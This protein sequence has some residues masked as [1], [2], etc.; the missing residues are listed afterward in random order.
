MA[1][2]HEALDLSVVMPA[3]NEEA[4]IE[5]ALTACLSSFDT[6]RIRGEVIVVN[7]GST[8]A[9]GALA[10]GF[11]R[12]DAR[13]RVLTH[14][15]PKGIGASFW[16]GVDAAHGSAVVMLPGDGENDPSEIFRYHDILRSV[17]IVIPFVYNKHARSLYRNALSF[18]Y[19]FIINTTFMVYF[20]YTNGTNIY[21]RTV[22]KE[23]R[24][25]STGFFYQTDILIRLVK[26]GYLF[27]EVPYRLGVRR[28]GVSR[29]ATFPS[30]LQ[31]AR[32]YLR[33][34]KDI[35]RPRAA[36]PTQYVPDSMT[37]DRWDLI[38]AEERKPSLTR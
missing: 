18:A 3:L 33:L 21:R 17:D 37:R 29:A 5:G 27:A 28:G 7:D 19:R 13:V 34:V 9:T 26:K 22:L 12:R 2:H 35:Y 4:N 10:L 31:V 16:D 14:P 8:D 6:F 36:A 38:R 30:F 15:Q 11:S 23:L 1:T 25:R 24:H 20:N 32:G